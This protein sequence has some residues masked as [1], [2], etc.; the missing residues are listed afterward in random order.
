M[1]TALSASK[2]KAIEAIAIV[3][4]RVGYSAASMQMLSESTNL[5]KSSL[6]HHFPDGKQEMALAVLHW[7]EDLLQRELM[8]PLFVSPEKRQQS[9]DAFLKKLL[10]YYQGGRLGCLLG[11][12]SFQDCPQTVS[13]E[14][15]R[16]MRVW[17]QLFEDYLKVYQIKDAKDKAAHAV[18][19]I[20]GGL[21]LSV[22]TQ[23]EDYFSNA[24]KDVHAILLE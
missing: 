12:L 2:L 3:F 4:R 20:Q 1:S 23:E 7:V 22:S 17:I 16:V 15:A 5:G 9:V 8:Q 18:R 14:V 13:D 21:I 6:Y 11:V 19:A 24:L 10:E